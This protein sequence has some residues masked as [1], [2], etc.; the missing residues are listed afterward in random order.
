MTSFFLW[1]TVGKLLVFLVGM[2]AASAIMIWVERRLSAMIQDR[3][4]PNRANT[5]RLQL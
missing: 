3:I 4:G 2:L 5:G 1:A